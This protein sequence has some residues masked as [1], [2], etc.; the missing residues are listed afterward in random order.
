MPDSALSDHPV[1]QLAK[2]LI[3]C[4]S[5]N[6]DLTRG[7]AGE[8]AVSELIAGR[9][10]AAGMEVELVEVRPGRPNVIGRLRGSGGGRTLMLCG[11]TDVVSA[12]PAGFSP[13]IT[14]G[15]LYGRGS[16]DME[17][18]LGGAVVAA[19]RLS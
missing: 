17:G 8:G 9:L 14:D 18:G 7:G 16:V 5:T 13:R 19:E 3:A 10:R 1:T 12:D 2:A 6:P 4:D 11:H 15:R